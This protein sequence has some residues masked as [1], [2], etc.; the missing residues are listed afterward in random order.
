MENVEFVL[1]LKVQ[2]GHE[3][4]GKNKT[5]ILVGIYHQKIRKAIIFMVVAFQG[6][7]TPLE[8]EYLTPGSHDENWKSKPPKKI[9]ALGKVSTP[10]ARSHPPLGLVLEAMGH[11]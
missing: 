11:K 5:M 3:W 4:N 6:K 2:V 7:N 8:V 1:T 10:R 9:W